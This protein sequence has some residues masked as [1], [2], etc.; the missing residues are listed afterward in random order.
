MR[1]EPLH[2]TIVATAAAASGSAVLARMRRDLRALL[3]DTL[4]RLGLEPAELTP[5]GDGCRFRV[6]L[7]ASVPPRAA[8]VPFVD[9]L[10]TRLRM[11]RRAGGEV[12]RLRLRVAV[13]RGS[14]VAEPG[15]TYAGTPLTDVARLLDADAGRDLLDGHPAADLVLLVSKVFYDDVVRGG[16]DPD[17]A[18]FQRV[19][20]RTEGAD[21][22]GWAYVPG[23]VPQAP[24]PPGAAGRREAR[25]TGGDVFH[26]P[27]VGG[28]YR[29]G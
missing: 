25:T 7:P 21:G 8:L 22:Y 27:V 5:I 16:T 24:P 18:L 17:P 26:G 19:P 1:L 29:H 28:D 11:R 9:R 14:L 2:H 13:H 3:E 10:G 12:H 15:G 4:T 6:L 23:I 20:V